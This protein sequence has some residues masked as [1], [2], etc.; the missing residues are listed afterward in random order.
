MS[1]TDLLAALVMY[2]LC[3]FWGFFLLNYAE[4]TARPSAWLKGLMGP[5]WGYPLSCAFCLAWWATGFLW[6]L[7]MVPLFYVFA[8]PVLHLF[9]D[10]A[11]DRLNCP[12]VLPPK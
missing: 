10:A 12:P 4:L 11:Y 2:V 8:A 6:F 5:R 1:A 9:V 7:G 3:L